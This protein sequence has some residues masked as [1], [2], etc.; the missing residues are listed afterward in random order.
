[1]ITIDTSDWRELEG[2]LEKLAE[3][4]IPF[5]TRSMLN[6]SAFK[7]QTVWRGKVGQKMTLRNQF[8]KQS[9]QVDQ[10]RGLRINSMVATLG[11]IAPFMEDQEFG[12]TK[13]KS[14]V[15]GVAIPT[16]YSAG[17]AETARPRTRLPR[18]PNQLKN[19]K[20]RRKAKRGSTIRQRNMAAIREAATSG[21]KFV[22]LDLGRRQGIFKVVGGKTR[23]RIKMVHDLSRESV[24]IPPNPTL[25]PSIPIIERLMP[26]I[27]RKALIF[28]LRRHGIFTE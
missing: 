11:S 27:Y 10:A 23:P 1:M 22:Y 15:E 26:G 17:L 16:S 20:L 5:A 28:Q 7:G 13:H 9:I 8:A 18:R 25:Q 21:Q 14:G 2:A 3:R 19:I 12:T 6:G 24:L 4:A